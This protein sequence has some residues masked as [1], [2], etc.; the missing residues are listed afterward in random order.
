[1]TRARKR[2]QQIGPA[3]TA[4][5]ISSLSAVA[6]PT[7]TVQ[8]MPT[9]STTIHAINSPLE[10]PSTQHGPKSQLGASSS[11]EDEE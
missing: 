7:P 2:Q 6:A 1:M 3:M 11:S 8:Q 9:M 4:P 5:F 10:R